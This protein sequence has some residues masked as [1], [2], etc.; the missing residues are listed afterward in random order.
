MT[1]RLPLFLLALLA[2][3]GVAQAQNLKVGVLDPDLIVVRM[4]EYE[5]V[6]G[7]IAQL[8]AQIGA[9]LQAKQD[10]AVAINNELRA[11]ADSPVVSAGAREEKQANLQRLVGELQN[12]EEQGLRYLSDQEVRLLQPALIRLNTAIQELAEEMGIDLVMTPVANN[13]PVLLYA[14]FDSDR[15]VDMTMPLFA[16]L[17]IEIPEEGEAAVEMSTPVP[18]GN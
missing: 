3:S 18:P 13:A 10:S 11:M 9:T 4:P 15:V 14:N 2:A 1:F 7:Q 6:R 8:E 12:G 17:G 5:Q 16:K